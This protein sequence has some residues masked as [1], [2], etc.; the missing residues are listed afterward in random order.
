MY[1]IIGNYQGNTQDEIIDEDFHTT[2][3]ARRMLAEYVMAFGADWGPLWI[4]DR[5]GN[6]I[7]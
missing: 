3:Y 1:K 4:V 5:N 6:H 7:D 2:G